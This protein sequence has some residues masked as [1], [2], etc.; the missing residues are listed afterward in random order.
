[1]FECLKC[2]SRIRN[3]DFRIGKWAGLV[4]MLTSF[5]FESEIR[6]LSFSESGIGV[7]RIGNGG[8]PN[9]G[10]LDEVYGRTVRIYSGVARG[11]E[12]GKDKGLSACKYSIRENYDF[13]TFLDTSW[14]VLFG[15]FRDGVRLFLQQY[16]HM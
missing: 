7:F 4:V 1:M 8:I 3:F 13:N 9:R 6:S 10:T 14:L 2:L 16:G 11:R 12:K 5:P 15:S